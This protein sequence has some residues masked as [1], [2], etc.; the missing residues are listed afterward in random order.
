MEILVIALLLLLNGIFAMY[1]IALISAR[2]SSLEEEAKSGRLGARTALDLLAEPEKVLSAIQVGITLI[3]IASGAFAGLALAE[4]VAPLLKNIGWLAPHAHTLSVIIVVG[5]IAYLSLII[6]ELVPKTIALNNAEAI[7]I[8]LSPAMKV[9]G[10]V[11][12][13]VVWILSISTKIV[14]KLFG[15]QNRNEALVTEE[16]LRMFL[17]K[18]SEHGVIEKEES[19]MINEVIRFG[20][21]RAGALMVPRVDV[22]WI[23]IHQT[24]DEILSDVLNSPYPRMPVCE[25]EI[26]NIKGVVNVNEVLAYYIQH[27]TLHLDELLLDPLYIPEQAPAL[28][29]LEM[30]RETKKHFGI[31]INEYGSM[32]GIITLHDLTENIMG[33]LPALGDVDDPEVFQ[34]EDGSY[35]IDGSMKVEDVEDLLKVPSFFDRDDERPA[36]NTLGGLAMYQ[37]NRIPAIGDKFSAGGYLFEIV[38][39][40]GNRVDKVLVKSVTSETDK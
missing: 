28:K 10:S 3:G 27:Q 13:P 39:M 6:G 12:Y 20:D 2:R 31:V 19:D 30:F 24:N 21:K 18:G 15:V 36:V 14:L 23:D 5:A 17:K 11:T 40:D 26:D 22:V 1:E 29:V 25:D 16:E 8:F 34:R 4:D 33:D 37:L 35:L 7:A 32:E 9:F 38:D